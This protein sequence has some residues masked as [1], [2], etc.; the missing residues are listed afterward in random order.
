MHVSALRRGENCLSAAL[1]AVLEPR[2][3]KPREV[4]RIVIPGHNGKGCRKGWGCTKPLSCGYK[5]N[6]KQYQAAH[7]IKMG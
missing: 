1:L 3:N 5:H 2:L 6:I 7:D 4:S